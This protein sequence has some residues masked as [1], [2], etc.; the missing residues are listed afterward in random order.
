MRIGVG[1]FSSFDWIV[2]GA[3]LLLLVIIGYLTSRNQHTRESFFLGDRNM[4]SWA[5]AL[6]VLATTLSAATFVSVPQLAYG[7]DLTYVTLNIG[8]IIAAFL[9][10]RMFLPPLYRAGTTT[11]Y[12]YLGSRYGL[13]AQMA[14]S[15]MFLIGRLLASGARLFIAAIAFSLILT[16]KTTTGDLV[17]AIVLFGIIGLF[18]TAAGGIKA[19]IWTDVVQIGIVVLTATLSIFLLLKAIPLAGNEIYA[20]LRDYQGQDKL[21]ILDFRFQLDLS[22]T[23]WTGIIASTFVSTSAYSVDQDMVQRMLTTRGPHEAGRSLII[24]ILVGIPVV[25]LFLF[26]GLLLSIYYGRPDLMG[27]EAPFNFLEDT[28]S[29]FPY[30]ILTHLPVGLKGLAMAGLL[31][32]AMSSFDSAVNAMASSVLADLYEPWKKRVLLRTELNISKRNSR[33]NLHVLS[34]SL[35][36]PRTAV[37]LM[38]ILLILFAILAVYLQSM[39]SKTLIDFALGVMAFA[40]APLLG[41]FSAAIFTKRG[42]S[43]SVTIALV[44]GCVLVLLLQP[45]ALPRWFD[46]TPIAW[47]WWWVVVSPVSYLVCVAGNPRLLSQGDTIH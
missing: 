1:I 29:V 2:L 40:N 10:A 14:A 36:A 16:G 7:G 24:S 18:Y 41:I 46:L 37:V 38:G 21:R 33:G 4:P 28:K 9:V 3:Y 15:F 12:G 5:V 42:N 31:A 25:C 39:G 13:T 11:V 6:S 17:T 35:S 34:W 23:I 8:G 19:V 22:F 44:I 30:F 43:Q 20:V 47:P 32:A 45:Y 26:I 27:G